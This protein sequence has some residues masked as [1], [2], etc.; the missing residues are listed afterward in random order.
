MLKPWPW[1]RHALDHGTRQQ[2]TRLGLLFTLTCVLV[3][4]AAFV[5]A[6][7]LLFLILALLLATWMV[8]GF[9]GRLSLAGLELDFLLPDH[10]CAG[11]KLMGR[12][13]IR[14]TKRWMASFSIHVAGSSDSGLSRPLYFPVIPGRA[15]IEAPVELFFARRGAYR[16]NSFRFSTRFPFGFAER[17]INVQLVRDIVVYP[18]IDPQP[19]FE[20]LLISLQGE[21]ASFYRGQGND[22]YRIRPY[23]VLESAHHVDWKATAH[24]GDLQ[25]REFA[26]EREQ[27][28]A[29]F[30]DLDVPSAQAAWFE[31][32]VDRCAFLAWN[33]SR[34]GSRIRFCTQDVDWQLP[35]EADV[36]TILKYL[37][38]VSP[39][40]GKRLE[41]AHDRDVFEI[42][43]ST[44]PERLLEAG[45]EVGGSNMRL[46]T[47]EEGQ[48]EEIRSQ[49]SGSRI[50]V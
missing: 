16:Q 36:Y 47:P 2:V 49:K 48:G 24:T 7:N 21:I 28:V 23:E 22:F 44:S 34:R 26:R 9:I 42:V 10:L 1:L 37:A 41:A 20:E 3:S 35:E 43:F 40:Q 30:L 25:V 19:G 38:I 39:R 33:L 13:V 15:R 11:R 50:R 18:S 8:S 46:L 6:N 4:L 45:W 12:V 27:A 14:N 17:R 29:F 32:A 31:T 5:S